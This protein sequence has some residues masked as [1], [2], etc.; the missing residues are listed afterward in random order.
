MIEC[1]PAGRDSKI[2]PQ[3]ALQHTEFKSSHPV[4][5]TVFQAE[6]KPELSYIFQ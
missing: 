1:R 5:Q 2:S 6:I 4:F 3:E